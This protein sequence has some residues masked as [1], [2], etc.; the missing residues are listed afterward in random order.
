RKVVLYS[1]YDI[2][3][4]FK[5]H[6]DVRGD[7]EEIKL[8]DTLAATRIVAFLQQIQ[9]DPGLLKKLT[10]HFYRNNEDNLDVKKW[11]AMHEAG[12]PVWRLRFVDFAYRH[13]DYRI[14]YVASASRA[15]VH[16]LAIC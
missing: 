10:T 14:F 8:L 15:E 13:P 5:L 6:R 4:V 16:I 9:V 11:R 7:L 2:M 3:L 1:E 12:L